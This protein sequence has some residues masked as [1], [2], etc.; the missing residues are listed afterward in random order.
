MPSV[1]RETGHAAATISAGA[2]LSNAINLGQ[3]VIVALQL[4]SGWDAAALT[5]QGS[6]DGVTFG[7]IYDDGGTEVTIASGTI[8]VN[9][10]I[11]NAGIL[12]KLAGVLFLKV[13]SG[14]AGV[15]V[16]QTAD[17]IIRVMQKA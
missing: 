5:F 10:T 4:P 3:R 17:R 8:V 2:S 7:D 9:R 1:S 14:T 16:N 15:P 12:E 6:Y 13:R 11:V